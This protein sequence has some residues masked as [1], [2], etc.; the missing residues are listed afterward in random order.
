M[1]QADRIDDIPRGGPPGVQLSAGGAAFALRSADARSVE[2]LL[3]DRPDAPRPAAVH[4]LA[5]EA[6]S[7][8]WRIERPGIGAGQLY[9]YRVVRA[10]GARHWVLDPCARA[11]TFG[12]RAWGDRT[13]L[14]AGRTPQR[15]ARFPKAAVVDDAFDWADDAPPRTPWRDTVIY[16]VSIRSFTRGPGAGVR[17]PGTYEGLVER[18]P[19]LRDLGVTAV[20]L[21]PVHEFNELEFFG[22]GGP[23]RRLLNAWGYSTLG[24][25]APMAR[26]A[27]DPDPLAA[28]R[29][30]KQMV[31][32]L[33]A[34]GIEVILDVVYNHTGEGGAE[35]P[36][37]HLK[38]LDPAAYYHFESDGRTHFNATG[39]GNT[40]RAND[41]LAIELI[42]ES[43][44]V[45]TRTM[46]VDGFRFDLATALTRGDDGAP[47]ARPP[48]LDRIAA[49]PRLRGVKLIAEP[50]DAHGHLQVGHFPAPDWAEWNDR[51][52]DDVRAFWTGARGRLGR[53]ATRLAGSADLYDH[54]GR[55]PLT[56]INYVACH[57]GFTL[58]DLVR[59]TRKHN[60]A[61]AEDNRDGASHNFS[62]NH[63]VEGDTDDP[64]VEAARLRH[65]KNLAA[66][67]FLAQG[68]PMIA[69]GDEFAR[70]QQGN[71]NAYAQDNAIGW[72]DWSFLERY[73]ELHDF[74]RALIAFRRA[75][76][77]LR[78]DRFFAGAIDG[79]TDGD[80]LWFG[81]DGHTPDWEGGR[82]LA[83]RIDGS[84]RH[85]DAP[86]DGSALF[87]AFN[88][89]RA[90]A[91][92][93]LPSA[94]SGWTLAWATETP[95]PRLDAASEMLALGP[96]ACAALVEAPERAR[97]HR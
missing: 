21:M 28:V 84:A 1:A 49:D 26:F 85:T 24:F 95:A 61:N 75:H 36:V 89:G 43:L 60:A 86:A 3:F 71:N 47:M 90:P 23:R 17:H 25:L 40:L 52:R 57:D 33:H 31:K 77:A 11:V 48:L 81:P 73:R 38:A 42:V 39:C 92:F 66:S 18:I 20:E 30:F 13:G 34:A 14:R 27:A 59:Y 55:G 88:A 53:F 41:P 76:P 45:W 4:A 78:R 12:G 80:I 67:L 64:A 35:G 56:G 83:C 70:T 87:L 32:A 19:Y 72:L 10:D 79:G 5:R 63:G 7:D 96:T 94:P 62:V 69:A 82:A 51:F 16:E 65:M 37:Y 2:L 97:R 74:V 54:D 44:A 29:A 22:E 8:L 68:V 9:G 58:G 6:G 50:W 91:R 93:R 46:R 15:G